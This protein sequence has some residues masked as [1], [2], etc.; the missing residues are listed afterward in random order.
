MKIFPILAAS[1]LLIVLAQP[2][3][4]EE[5]K[6]LTIADDLLTKAKLV[7][8][9]LDGD[10]PLAGLR[11]P[12]EVIRD[13]WGVA[14][15]YAK[16]AADLFFAQGFIAAQD[17]LFQIDLWRRQGVGEMAEVFGPDYLPADRFAR[18]LK[19]RGDMKAEWASY[20]P[21]TKEI[22][23][24]FANGI[25]ACI[26][27]LGDKLPIEFQIL[28]YKP[29]KWQPEDVLGRMSGIYMSQNFRNEI[30][31]AQLIAAVGIEKA[32]W[33]APVDPAREYTSPLNDD[34]LKAVNKNILA[35]YEAA[36]KGL[37]FKPSKSE[38]N[39]WVVSGE[40]SS[41]GK[42]L[43]AS[44]PHRA[45]ALPSLRYLVHLNAPG[46]NVIG[47]GE[48]G[49]P[50]VAIG[51]NDKIAWGFTIIGTDQADFF[52][53]ETNPEDPD[54]YRA[55]GR[56]EKMTVVKETIAVKDG[57]NSSV[58][59]R[60]TRHGP[61]FYHDKKRHRAYAL[62][63]VGND[64]GGA[65]YLGS[66]AVGRAQDQKSFLE[67]LKRWKIPGLNFVYA[68]VE[69]NIG[70][71][72]AASTPIRPKHDGLL[73]V[74]G[75]GGFEW[76]GFLDVADL[77][78]SFNPKIGWLATANHKILPEGY[79]H[80]IGYEFSP[81]YRFQRIRDS[82]T[83]KDKWE[84]N[85]FKAIQHDDLTIPG[86]KLAGL[87]KAVDLRDP[88][89]EPFKK[90]LVEWDGKLA[91]DAKA[92][93]LYAFW[94]R[95]LQE[96]FANQY[97]KE[98]K[99][100]FN[101]LSGLPVMLAALESADRHW[102]GPDS[103]NARDERLR[104]TFAAAVKKLQA[105]PEAKQNRW[106]SLHGVTFHHGLANLDPILAKAF[107]VGPFERT[108]DVN[109]PNNTRYDDKF[110]QIH[111]ASYRHLIDLDDWD[112]TIATSTP[113]QSGQ[114]GSPHY[115]DLAPLWAKGEYFPLLFS[116]KKIDDVTGHRLQLKPK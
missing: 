56:W 60:Y 46:W 102:F 44:D 49:L 79:K 42:P 28:G 110:Q 74:P 73:P 14:H 116:R 47:A 101:T 23:T 112:R 41:S 10:V 50:G 43:L 89:L 53:E 90:T 87:V 80:Q 5:P 9:K 103:K 34:E 109:T 68:D 72:A 111:G 18:L 65:A 52:V 2:S 107:N 94:L 57:K 35:D 82:L 71:I 106:G 77:P 17:R 21:D 24:S 67:A 8:P 100:I 88:Q 83:S 51:H 15:I 63:W 7:L 99:G 6:R 1:F 97:P 22:A 12:V 78:Q 85:D 55:N 25:N 69:G 45:I 91:L 36:T 39:N 54:E 86:V 64:P 19:Y 30:Q 31:R 59:L 26:D 4:A 27:Q 70:W 114:P 61:V 58:E 13:R 33:L 81:P 93:P 16:N 11:E 104:T 95:E 92:G 96:S 66:L 32:R 113:G 29:K 3:S 76:S 105:L 20:S 84:L 48:P 37:S 115:A 38:S 62:R 98:H 75:D 40:H 108:G